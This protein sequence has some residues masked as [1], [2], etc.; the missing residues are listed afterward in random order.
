MGYETIRIPEEL[1][2][3]VQQAF[4]LHPR[5]A[6]TLGEL[7]ESFARGRGIPRSENLL[8][9]KP[10]PH[11]VKINGR[12]LYT[13][14]F[15][16]ALMLPF[17]LGESP[18]VEVRSAGPTGGEVFALVTERGVEASPPGTVVSFGAARAGIGTI[19]EMLCPYLNAFPSQTD[20]ERWAEE[21]PQAETIV[22]SL[23]EAFDLARD[24]ASG[25]EGES[26]RC[27]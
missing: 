24:W 7:V 23:E 8:S 26:Y 6:D 10:T 14:C 15:V 22:F 21:T 5:R 2:E 13:F 17:V 20:Y 27:C 3:R 1:A 16:D 11:E 12:N 4:G 25:S 19:C 18:A 9:E